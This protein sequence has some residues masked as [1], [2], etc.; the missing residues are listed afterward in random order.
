MYNNKEIEEKWLNYWKECK[1]FLFDEKNNKPLYIID[2]PPPFTNG[3]LHMGQVFWVSYIDTI[4]RYKRLAGFNVLYPQGWDMHG[5]PTEIAVEKKYG[6]NLSR[7]EFYQKALEL[8]NSNIEIM[9]NLMLKLGATFDERYE[10]KTASDDYKKKVQLALIEMYKKGII[11]RGVH[12][13]SWCTYCNTSISREE[14]E[15]KEE[16][17]NLNYIKFDIVLSNEN[18][19]KN[20]KNNKVNK[21]ENLKNITIATTRPELL[22]A[23]VAIMVNNKDKRFKD[24][25]GSEAIVPIFNRKVKIIGDESIDQKF[26]TGCEMICTFGDINDVKMYHKYNLNLID[27]IDSEGKLI[28]AGKFSGKNIKEARTLILNE[29]K[30]EGRLEKQEV[31]RHRVKIHDR[32]ET[33]VELL[34]HTQ[35]FIKTKEYVNKLKELAS[36]I[37]W[38]PEQNKQRI[39]DWIDTI[40]WDWNISRSR[41][42][43]T[44][45]PFWHCKN[46]G[47]ILPAKIEELPIDPI[48]NS[49]SDELKCPK[50]NSKMVAD[51]DTCDGWVDTCITPLVVAGWPENKKRFEDGFPV[52]IRIQGS[53]I[54]RTWA[55]YTIVGSFAVANNKPFE[56]LLTHGM[57]LGSDGREMHKRWGN[58]VFPEEL[59]EKYSIDAIR[60]WAALSGSIGKDKIFSYKDIEYANSFITKLYNS[61]LFIKNVSVDVVPLKEPKEDLNLFDMWILNK[62]NKIVK[63]VRNAYDNLLLFEALSSLINFYWH[64]FCDYYIEDIKHRVYTKEEDKQGSRNAAIFVLNYILKNSIVMLAPNIPFVSEE[65]NSMFSSNSIFKEKLPTYIEMPEEPSF[66]MNGLLFAASFEEDPE[67]YGEIL[68]KIVSEARKQKAKAKIALNKPITSININVPDKYYKAVVISQD[69]IKGILKA[70]LVNITQGKELSISINI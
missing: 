40:E 36:E 27:A 43:G 62:F 34:Q 55:F 64:D 17:T 29:L 42:F 13:V 25:I 21:L 4:A 31:I 9:K 68:N 52:D 54:I 1:I 70:S 26:G 3:A 14:M 30:D 11:Y 44:P 16:D 51:T 23:C 39:F 7:T 45:L 67:I 49:N 69:E 15:E 59:M 2:T 60:L 61:A 32:C 66:V 18:S 56:T 57:I 65:I 28:N 47:N 12:P 24:L 35:W 6:K 50:C 20:S 37:K 8:S 5:F 19:K 33:E 48:T 58:G 22:H 38:V 41:I 46:C 10:Y 53:D 63:T